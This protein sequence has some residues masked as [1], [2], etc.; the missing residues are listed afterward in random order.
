VGEARLAA[1][2]AGA[3]V[4]DPLVTVIGVLGIVSIVVALSAWPA[5]R[6][7]RLLRG[8][9]PRPVPVALVWAV[10]WTGALP[11]LLIGV[12]YALERGRGRQPVPVGTAL[13]G[14]GGR[15]AVRQPCSVPA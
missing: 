4:I 10:A 5:I 1:G 11:S 2:L 8:Q 6:D 3:A 13:I 7:A 15:R 14:A 9:P 12:R